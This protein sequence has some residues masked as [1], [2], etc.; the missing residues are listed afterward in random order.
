MRKV[1]DEMRMDIISWLQ[2]NLSVDVVIETG[3]SVGFIEVSVAINLCGEEICKEST[4]N[5][6]NMER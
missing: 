1:T 3:T 2:E 6:I 4:Y 5:Y